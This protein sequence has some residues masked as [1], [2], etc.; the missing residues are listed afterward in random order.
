MANTHARQYDGCNQE[1]KTMQE[2]QVLVRHSKG[3]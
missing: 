1:P 3:Y 2:V